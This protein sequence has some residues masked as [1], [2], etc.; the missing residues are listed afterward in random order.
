[1]S[2]LVAVAASGRRAATDEATVLSS[3]VPLVAILIAHGQKIS[4]P[5]TRAVMSEH[6]NRKKPVN[7]DES[8]DD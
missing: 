6:R 5:S 1:M 2:Q 4:Q 8:E 3:R 7:P